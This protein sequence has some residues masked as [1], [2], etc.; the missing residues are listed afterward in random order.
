MS[1]RPTLTEIKVAGR[2]GV[3]GAGEEVVKRMLSGAG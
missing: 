3:R 1:D 2:V